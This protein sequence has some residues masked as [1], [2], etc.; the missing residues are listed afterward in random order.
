MT[1]TTEEHPFKFVKEMELCSGCRTCEL[2]C[3]FHHSGIFSP[4]LSS[5]KIS[6]SNRT[7]I[8]RWHL[9]SSCDACKNE[10]QPFCVK[11]CAYGALRIG[12]RK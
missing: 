10:D 9:D 5:I 11:Y 8:I 3:S 2:A 6:K 7:G 4:E 12:D 1:K